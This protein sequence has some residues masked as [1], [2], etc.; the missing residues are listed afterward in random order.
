M[1]ILPSNNRPCIKIGTMRL[2]CY[3]KEIVA[4]GCAKSYQNDKIRLCSHRRKFR[5]NDIFVSVQATPYFIVR[6]QSCWYVNIVYTDIDTDNGECSWY[7]IGQNGR[8]FA[9]DIFRGIFVYEKFCILVRISLKIVLK[10]PID[11]NPALVQITAWRRIGDKPLSEP[12]LTWF[13]DAYMRH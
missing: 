2:K 11:N 5:H 10:G 12:M 13:T 4:I 1:W 9:D 8:L 7:R 6:N 3:F